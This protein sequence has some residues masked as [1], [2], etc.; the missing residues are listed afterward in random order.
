MAL[1]NLPELPRLVSARRVVRKSRL[2]QREE[3]G[4][5]LNLLLSSLPC[6]PTTVSLQNPDTIFANGI[7]HR[8]RREVGAVRPLNRSQDNSSLRKDCRVPQR[9]EVGP[10]DLRI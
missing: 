2:N 1:D 4:V 9:L 3:Y 5:L 10:V 7:I 6:S 8:I